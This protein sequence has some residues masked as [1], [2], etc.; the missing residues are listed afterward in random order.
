VSKHLGMKYEADIDFYGEP[1]GRY[2]LVR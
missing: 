2:V 1:V